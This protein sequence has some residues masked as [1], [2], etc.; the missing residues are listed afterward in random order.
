MLQQLAQPN[1]QQLAPVH[2]LSAGSMSK[3]VAGVC[4]AIVLMAP[5][6]LSAMD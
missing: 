5:P 6:A 4:V 2:H 3:T 1:E